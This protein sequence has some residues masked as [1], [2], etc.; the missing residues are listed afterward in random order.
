MRYFLYFILI[1]LFACYQGKKEKS[2]PLIPEDRFIQLLADYHLA[3]GIAGTYTFIKKTKNIKKLTITDSV[4]VKYG[5]NKAIFDS[6]ISFYAADPDKLDA[7]YD[8]VITKLSRMQAEVQERM[9]K[10]EENNRQSNSKKID[11][12][13]SNKRKDVYEKRIFERKKILKSTDCEKK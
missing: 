8:K 1:F 4:I 9:V 5:Y 11:R 6:T 10:S 13:K 2:Y 7:L 3:Q 12:I